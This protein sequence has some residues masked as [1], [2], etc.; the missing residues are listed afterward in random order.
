MEVIHRLGLSWDKSKQAL[1]AGLGIEVVEGVDAFE[2]G[3][4]DPRWP[5]VQPLISAWKLLDI[6]TTRFSRE[7]LRG[8]SYLDMGPDWHH[9]YPQPDGA[10]GYLKETY[11]VA[12]YCSACGIGAKQS[13]PFRMK[14]EPKWGKR[15]I[16]QLNWVFDEYF[17]QPDVWKTVF[18][19]FG[20]GSCPVKHHRTSKQLTTVV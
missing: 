3:E 19:P 17:V 18:E 9:G 13:A 4:S 7:E 12:E 2:I 10:F 14:G 20:V 15:H 11:D 5:D 16:L 8:A 6:V 1:L